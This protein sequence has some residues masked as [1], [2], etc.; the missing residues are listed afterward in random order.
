MSY[1]VD[2]QSDATTDPVVGVGSDRAER[3]AEL[4]PGL[5]RYCRSRLSD[6]ELAEDTTQEV[7]L[8]AMTAL[9][10]VDERQYPLVALV[11]GIA[12][13]K[14][15]DAWRARARC[16]SFPAPEVP[17]QQDTAAGPEDLALQAEAARH[18][19]R[20]LDTLPRN[21]RELLLLRVAAGLS[22]EEAGAVLGMT[23]GAVR[24]AQH[25][26][27]HRLRSFV[28]AEGSDA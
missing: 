16:R 17:E 19:M 26:A 20:L 18:A 9:P 14:V 10:R 8:A 27:L 24:V 6:R 23:A 28:A 7:L 2:V 4:R 1:V 13:H 25:R 15:A 5:L 12:A 21:Q 3:L 11:F 22:A